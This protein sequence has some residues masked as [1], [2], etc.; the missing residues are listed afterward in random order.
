MTRLL[1]NWSTEMTHPAMP[2]VLVRGS[3]EVDWLEGKRFLIHRARTDHS[4]FPA[5]ISIIGFMDRDREGEKPNNG[6]EGE[7]RL[8]MHYFDS[9]G[10]FRVYETSF[11]SDTW[12]LWRDSP[13]FSQ[14]FAGVVSSG[15]D[16]VDGRWEVSEDGVSWASDLE[17]RYRRR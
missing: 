3:V 6:D 17:I 2:G 9:R 12:R 4:D 14:R 13:K 1:G 8:C 16:G 10:V 11:D 15:G 7:P 5:S